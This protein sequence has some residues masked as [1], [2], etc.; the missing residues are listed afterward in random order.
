MPDVRQI[1][2][3]V[4]DQH[5]RRTDPNHPGWPKCRCGFDPEE[6]ESSWSEH[7]TDYLLATFNSLG[8]GF[9]SPD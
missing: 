4:L 5:S 8:V 1:A 3:D 6:S 2:I 7:V 9:A